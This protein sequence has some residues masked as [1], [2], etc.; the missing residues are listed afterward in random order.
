MESLSVSDT[1]ADATVISISPY[2]SLKPTPCFSRDLQLAYGSMQT[3][4]DNLG[5]FTS[6]LQVSDKV[7]KERAYVIED[8]DPC[9]EENQPND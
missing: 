1:G 3:K 4:F 8:L 6:E 9:L 5:T 2:H 7:A